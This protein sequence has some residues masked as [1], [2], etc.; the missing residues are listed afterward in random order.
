MARHMFLPG[1][2]LTEADELLHCAQHLAGFKAP[3][4]VVSSTRCRRTR[5][6]SC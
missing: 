1:A 5:A 3:K 6:A 2:E 4:A